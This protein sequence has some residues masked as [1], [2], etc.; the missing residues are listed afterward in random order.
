MLCST[1]TRSRWVPTTPACRPCRRTATKRNPRWARWSRGITTHPEFGRGTACRWGSLS[2]WSAAWRR[3]NGTMR[4]IGWQNVSSHRTSVIGVQ[5]GP[6][7]GPTD[8]E[9]RSTTPRNRNQWTVWW[10]GSHYPSPTRGGGWQSR[11]TS[12][13]DWPYRVGCW[14]WSHWVVWREL[15][16]SWCPR[17][18]PLSNP[19]TW[20]YV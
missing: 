13:L 4:S 5:V 11:A 12:S 17:I 3:L 16:T 10:I 6:M 8:Y 18:G 19:P 7:F 1:P 9:L 15:G 14:E 2:T 20:C